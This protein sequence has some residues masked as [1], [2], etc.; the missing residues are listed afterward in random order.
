MDRSNPRALT[1]LLQYRA[2]RLRLPLSGTFELCP[3][4]NFSC[5]MCYV[6][7]TPGQVA[8]SPHPALTLAQWL[9]LAAQARQAGTLYLLLTGG[10]PLLW[11]DLWPLYERLVDMGF[12]VSINTNGSLI[13]DEA[14]ARFLRRPPQKISITLYGAGEDTYSRLCGSRSYHRVDRAIRALKTAGITVKLNCS[15]TGEN[16][17]DLDAVMAYAKD[18]ELPL[19]ATTY[20]FPPIRRDTALA[21]KNHR[22]SPEEAVDYQMRYLRHD[23]GETRFRQYLTQIAQHSGTVSGLEPELAG[24]PDGTVQCRA[25]RTSFWISWDG[26]MTPCGMMPSPRIP[27]TGPFDRVWE[28]LKAATDELRLS[29]VCQGCPSRDICHP[30]AAIAMAETGSTAGIPEYKCHMTQALYRFACRSVDRLPGGNE[31]CIKPKGSCL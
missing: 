11:P 6:R 24:C 31:E 3:V 26:F 12:L 20:M 1:E 15:V 5:R 28:D 21:G 22:L 10:E 23:R 4:C 27:C 17:K 14:V 9:E 16:A 29:G 18:L 25:G 19:A 30:C 2:D 8:A 13:D 7:Q